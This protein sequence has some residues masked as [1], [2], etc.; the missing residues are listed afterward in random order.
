MY[1]YC[2]HATWYACRCIS[3]TSL[4]RYVLEQVIMVFWGD[5][6]SKTASMTFPR[7]SVFVYQ[8]TVNGFYSV[9]EGPEAAHCVL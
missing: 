5:V 1:L 2:K 7:I 3:S 9:H 8:C 4:P 6:W